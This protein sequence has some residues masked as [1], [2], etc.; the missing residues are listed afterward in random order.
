MNV[1]YALSAF[2]REVRSCLALCKADIVLARR[3]LKCAGTRDDSLNANAAFQLLRRWIQ[4][5]WSE[6]TND[7]L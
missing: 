7:R 2:D 3:N 5:Q 1:A 6:T 4:V